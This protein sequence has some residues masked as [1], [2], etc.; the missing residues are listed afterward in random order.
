MSVDKCPAGQFSVTG[1]E[2]CDRCPRGSF[3]PVAGSTDCVACPRLQSTLQTGSQLPTHCLGISNYDSSIVGDFN[4]P[5]S[6]SR[7]TEKSRVNV[8]W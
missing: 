4:R 6:T 1:Y 5:L 7:Y 3:Q 8:K 2:P